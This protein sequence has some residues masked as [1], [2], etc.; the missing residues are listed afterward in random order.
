MKDG[1][2]VNGKKEKR[3]PKAVLYIHYALT[4][5]VVKIEETLK[6]KCEGQLS[7]LTTLHSSA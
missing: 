5:S 6:E 7:A 1:Q 4:N 3:E 2:K